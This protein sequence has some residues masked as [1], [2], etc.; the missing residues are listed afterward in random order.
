MIQL[1]VR[2]PCDLCMAIQAERWKIVE[3][4]GHALTVINPYQF[5]RSASAA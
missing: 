4:G 5:E 1:P 3:E 2:E